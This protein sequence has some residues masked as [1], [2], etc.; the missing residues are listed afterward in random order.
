VFSAF[1]RLC[2]AL[3]IAQHA[4]TPQTTFRASVDVTSLDVTVV[5]VAANRSVDLTPADFNV[6][7]D[8]AQRKVVTAEW[9]PLTT[10][11]S[12]K[13]RRA[14]AGRLQLERNLDGRPADRHRRGRT[15]HPHRRRDGHSPRRR[16][17]S[18][19]GCRRAIAWRSPASASA[20]RDG[21]YRRSRA[22]QARDLADGR[23]E[24]PARIDGS[25]PQH[26]ARRSAGDR[27]RRPG[28]VLDGDESRVPANCCRRCA[29]VCRQQ[30]ELEAQSLAQDVRIDADQ[31]IS[32]LREL[33]VGLSRIDAPK[34]LILISEGFVLNDESM[35]VDLGTWRAQARYERLHPEARQP[36]FEITDARMP[37]NPVRRPAGAYRRLELLPARA[38]HAVHR[39]RHGQNLFERIESELSGYYL[40]GV[41]SE[42]AT[43]TEVAFDSRRRA[44]ARRACPS[45]P[46]GVERQ[47]R[48]SRAALRACGRR[49]RPQLAALSSALPLRVASFALQGPEAGKVQMLIHADIGTDYAASKASRSATDCRQGRPA[50]RYEVGGR[51]RGAAARRRAL[52]AASTPRA[53]ASAGRLLVQAGGRRR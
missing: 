44:A 17:C 6:R 46:S 1:L 21:L 13:A 11:P 33:F 28:T 35:I 7:I 22:R 23:P 48:S 53:R 40:L 3:R 43:A 14:A 10:P 39:D 49:R 25:R 30:V 24:A 42:P 15:E 20:R 29:R 31:T 18:S 47:I 45:A 50:G 4:Q 38:R 8:G 12:D 26:R 5:D 16:I 19:I 34:T 27:A 2:G 51:A 32:N 52:A 36:L 9:V 37:I 41:E